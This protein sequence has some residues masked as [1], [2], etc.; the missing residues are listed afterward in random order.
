MK[1][2]GYVFLLIVCCHSKLAY[3]KEQVRIYDQWNQPEIRYIETVLRTFDR[4]RNDGKNSDPSVRT[5]LLLSHLLTSVKYR[6]ARNDSE[7]NYYY[8]EYAETSDLNVPK[9]T[10]RLMLKENGWF[11]WALTQ[12]EIDKIDLKDFS[13]LS[14][15][16]ASVLRALMDVPEAD[17]FLTS[18][19]TRDSL[20]QIKI[21]VQ[22]ER[23]F[24]FDI[25]LEAKF[26]DG[27][28]SGVKR[29]VLLTKTVKSEKGLPDNWSYK[30]QTKSEIPDTWGYK[31]FLPGAIGE[32]PAV[33]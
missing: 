2:I 26:G 10:Y 18:V 29:E 5:F 11:T 19:A 27:F 6:L 7:P 12:D 20:R 17:R 9:K 25:S 14:S 22:D 4:A 23:T 13:D 24:Q 16:G 30:V 21:T 15:D 31:G 28:N 33:K 8:A 1:I 3:A 32:T